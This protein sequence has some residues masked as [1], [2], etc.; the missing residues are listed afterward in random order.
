MNTVFQRCV[1]YA[2]KKV[3]FHNTPWCVNLHTPKTHLIMC[4]F[5]DKRC[6]WRTHHGVFREHTCFYSELWT[7][8]GYRGW[9]ILCTAGPHNFLLNVSSVLTG[10]SQDV[11]YFMRVERTKA[12]S[13]RQKQLWNILSNDENAFIGLVHFSDKSLLMRTL[14]NN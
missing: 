12:G 1:N 6:V 14:K 3:C 2:L 8:F 10:F 13:F 5:K 4:Y 9:S 11:W 7:A